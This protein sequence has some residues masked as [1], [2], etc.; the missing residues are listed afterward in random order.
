MNKPIPDEAVRAGMVEIHSNMLVTSSKHRPSSF[1]F[2]GSYG[3]LCQL[4]ENI[5]KVMD[6]AV[7]NAA[8][9]ENQRRT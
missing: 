1:S 3:D 5:Y 9:R 8:D 2:H 4:L 7:K 6:G